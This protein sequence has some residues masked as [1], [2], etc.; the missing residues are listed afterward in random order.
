MAEAGEILDRWGYRGVLPASPRW[1]GMFSQALLLNRSPRLEDLTTEAFAQLRAHPAN[2]EHHGTMLFALQRAVSSLGHCAPP[3]RAGNVMT[4]IE[5]ADPTWI[6]WVERWYDT[7][8]LSPKV[9]A[10]VR[11]LMAKAGRWLALEHSE[12]TEPSQ[13]TRQTCAAWVAAVDRMRVGDYV[14]RRDPGGAGLPC[15]LGRFGDLRVLQREPASGLGH[16]GADDGADL[17]REG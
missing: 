11:T 1:V 7:S 14:Q 8:S 16:Q 15:P 12:I 17:G 10:I 9:R 2:T 4:V 6:G 3:V 5:G 13:W